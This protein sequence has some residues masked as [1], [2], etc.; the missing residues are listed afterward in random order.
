MISIHRSQTP[1]AQ[2]AQ[3]QVTKAKSQNCNQSHSILLADI[4]RSGGWFAG[5]WLGTAIYWMA[6]SHMN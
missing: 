2:E 6:L 5:A 4:F 3:H 1:E